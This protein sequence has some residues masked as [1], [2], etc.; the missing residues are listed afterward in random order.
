MVTDRNQ[1]FRVTVEDL[2]R[3]DN[4]HF[5]WMIDYPPFVENISGPGRARELP[6]RGPNEPNEHP[7]AFQPRCEFDNISRSST[8]HRLMLVVA[9][10]AFLPVPDG[11]PVV[12]DRVP[13]GGHVV[14]VVWLFEKECP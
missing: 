1:V 7:L 2:N 4:L 12:F 3:S 11:G 14:R 6:S 13:P 5:A 8:Q 9:D 10:R